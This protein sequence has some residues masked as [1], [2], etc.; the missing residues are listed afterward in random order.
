MLAEQESVARRSVV[1]GAV[2]LVVTLAVALVHIS[3][4]GVAPSTAQSVME[5]A[6]GRSRRIP[7]RGRSTTRIRNTSRTPLSVR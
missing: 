4:P 2:A 5:G 3:G 1:R 6:R 7:S